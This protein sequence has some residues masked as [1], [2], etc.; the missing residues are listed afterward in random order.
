MSKVKSTARN[1]KRTWKETRVSLAAATALVLDGPGSEW[2]LVLRG[3]RTQPPLAEGRK[4]K[5]G[6]S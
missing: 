3:E 6:R 1:T 2:L 5:G 4:A